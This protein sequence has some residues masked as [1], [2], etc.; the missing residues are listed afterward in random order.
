[1]PYGYNGRILHLNLTDLTWEIETPDPKW[2]RTY[3]GG[4]SLAAYYLLKH[5]TPGLD[6]LSDR[7][8]LVFNCS[9]LTGAPLSGFSRYTVALRTWVFTPRQPLPLGAPIVA[10][11][12]ATVRGL[13]GSRLANDLV[14]D[15]EIDARQPQPVVQLGDVPPGASVFVASDRA[16][17]LLA[18]DHSLFE[19]RFHSPVHVPMPSRI[20]G[21]H[22]EKRWDEIPI[23]ITCDAW[24]QVY[25]R[26]R[27]E[28]DL[29]I[30]E[31]VLQ[32]VY[33]SRSGG[34]VEDPN[35]PA[36][37]VVEPTPS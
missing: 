34:W 30:V 35:R 28:G 9:V 23:C 20:R 26:I 22:R 29:Q 7:N 5:I 1:M 36:D 10:R 17:V 14:W 6:P 31:D 13:N 27:Y 18:H 15:F 19:L 25:N 8:V 12:A 2:Y 4:S 37:D 21:L 24:C 32:A 3:V 16:E 33:R 11:I